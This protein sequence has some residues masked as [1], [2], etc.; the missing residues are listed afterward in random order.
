V[1][2]IGVQVLVWAA[3]VVEVRGERLLRGTVLLRR[4]L[5]RVEV[6]IG[7]GS[8]SRFGVESMI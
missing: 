7:S 5:D 8:E 3:F 6:G 1:E 2:A 4:V